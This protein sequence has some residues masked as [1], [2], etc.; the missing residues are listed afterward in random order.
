MACCIPFTLIYSITQKD[1]FPRKVPGYYAALAYSLDWKPAI[2]CSVIIALTMAS[3]LQIMPDGKIHED[4]ARLT[5]FCFQFEKKTQWKWLIR[6]IA[7]GPVT[8][9][10]LF[11][12]K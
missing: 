6:E 7:W 5:L 1:L 11:L 4:A 3:L 12:K 2:S 10:P 8:F 9:F